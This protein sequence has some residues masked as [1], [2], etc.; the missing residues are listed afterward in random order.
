MQMKQPKFHTTCHSSGRSITSSRLATLRCWGS[1]A[2][3]PIEMPLGVSSTEYSS[4]WP[5]FTCLSVS[6]SLLYLSLS[7][8]Y[9]SSLFCSDVRIKLAS[10]SFPAHRFVLTA[11]ADHWL[12]SNQNWEEVAELG[13]S[14]LIIPDNNHRVTLCITITDWSHLEAA[15]GESLLRWVY[16]DELSVPAQAQKSES[17]QLDFFLEMLRAA[18]Q[19]KLDDLISTCEQRLM[20]MVGVSNCVQLFVRAEEAGAESLRTF[21]AGL[22]S[23]HWV[24]LVCPWHQSTVWFEFASSLSYRTIWVVRIW[25]PCPLNRSTGSWRS[26]PSI[27]FTLPS[28]LAARTSSSSTSSSTPTRWFPFFQLLFCVRNTIIKECKNWDRL[29]DAQ[30]WMSIMQYSK[31]NQDKYTRKVIIRLLCI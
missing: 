21:C 25:P 14:L 6:G 17:K 30:L 22:M 28:V 29:K 15:V 24:S 3:L 19:Y 23:S 31:N 26:I 1:L 9:S 5:A 27:P 10:G 16:V 2:R 20:P 13:T 18:G 4:S 7:P 8:T 12:T 11:R